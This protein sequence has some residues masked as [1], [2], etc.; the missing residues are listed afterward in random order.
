MTD[1]ILLLLSIVVSMLV[2]FSVG[3]MI[4]MLTPRTVTVTKTVTVVATP[5]P[6][7]TLVTKTP[8]KLLPKAA[9]NSAVRK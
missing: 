8:V 7:A 5:T 2:L 4:F 9:S 3:Y 6:T 1:R